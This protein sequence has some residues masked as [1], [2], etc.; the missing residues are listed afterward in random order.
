MFSSRSAPEGPLPLSI[1]GSLLESLREVPS[2]VSPQDNRRW[3]NP[4]RLSV[5]EV[6]GVPDVPTPGYRPSGSGSTLNQFR[7]DTPVPHD[8]LPIGEKTGERTPLRF[9]SRE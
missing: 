2:V 5:I 8:P 6:A 3:E 9:K 7:P 1:P 4:V